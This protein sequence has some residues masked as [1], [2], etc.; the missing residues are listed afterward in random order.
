MHLFVFLHT[1]TASCARMSQHLITFVRLF[2]GVLDAGE[3]WLVRPAS[4][5]SFKESTLF[6]LDL[7]NG[8]S[9]VLKLQRVK[10]CRALSRA[11]TAAGLSLSAFIPFYRLDV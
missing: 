8:F 11:S 10:T 4:S 1:L 7:G 2:K 5:P 3:T 6:V 9:V